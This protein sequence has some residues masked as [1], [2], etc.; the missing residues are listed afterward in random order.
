MEL[1]ARDSVV[2]LDV[3]KVMLLRCEDE[4]RKG[5]RGGS[6][7]KGKRGKRRTRI[8]EAAGPGADERSRSRSSRSSSSS[9]S[10]RKRSCGGGNDSVTGYQ[11]ISQQDMS[12]TGRKGQLV[13]LTSS[14]TKG[15]RGTT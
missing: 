7:E 11:G 6:G 9:S 14:R 8:R 15:M 4:S 1:F 12:G 2:G 3:G 10:S 5:G 13:T